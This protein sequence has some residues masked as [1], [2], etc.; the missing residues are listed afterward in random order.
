MPTS[1]NISDLEA[2]YRNH[3]R[4]KAMDRKTSIMFALALA[5][6]IVSEESSVMVEALLFGVP[7]IAVVDWTIPDRNPPRLASVPFPVSAPFLLRVVA[8]ALAMVRICLDVRS[9]DA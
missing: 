5:D 3:P 9:C 7:A 8:G 1:Q 6:V 4:V 2:K